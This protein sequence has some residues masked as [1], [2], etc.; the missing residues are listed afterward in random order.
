MCTIS[1]GIYGP[2]RRISGENSPPSSER[3]EHAELAASLV[4]VESQGIRK[5]F[6]MEDC[7]TLSAAPVARHDE[8]A[9]RTGLDHH[10]RGLKI[11][12]RIALWQHLTNRNTVSIE[13][14]D[15]A[16]AVHRHIEIA[17]AISAH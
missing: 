13:H 11:M 10:T 5:R 6:C 14:Q 1:V 7:G 16:L 15:S 8:E 17:V 3:V 2:R 9:V 4:R 12:A